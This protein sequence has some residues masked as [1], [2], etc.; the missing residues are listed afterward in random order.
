VC[1]S[2][3]RPGAQARKIG[4]EKQMFDDNFSH[5]FTVRILDHIS[6]DETEEIVAY[7]IDLAKAFEEMFSEDQEAIIIM[8]EQKILEDENL[9]IMTI[10]GTKLMRI[11]ENEI[12]R[13]IESE[14][15]FHMKIPEMVNAIVELGAKS[16]SVNFGEKKDMV[17]ELENPYI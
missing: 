7:E 16:A 17:L 4:K 12:V 15:P 8:N 5:D 9:L 3:Y 2:G 14:N 13:T 10:L 6:F 1:G 11:M